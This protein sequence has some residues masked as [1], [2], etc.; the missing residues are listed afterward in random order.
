MTDPRA[1]KLPQDF[2]DSIDVMVREIN[3][4]DAQCERSEYTDVDEAW[5]RLR[6]ARTLLEEIA[7][8][9][10]PKKKYSIHVRLADEVYATSEAEA[11]DM[12]LSAIED[13]DGFEIMGHDILLEDE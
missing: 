6:A 7:V 5:T 9:A 2:L 4:F 3:T 12:M 11:F 1:A 10:G 8:E 13:R